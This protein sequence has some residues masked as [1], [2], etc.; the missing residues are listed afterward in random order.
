MAKIIF[1]SISKT[2]K[3]GSREKRKRELCDV[4]RPTLQHP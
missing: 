4:W 3:K 1:H 2:L